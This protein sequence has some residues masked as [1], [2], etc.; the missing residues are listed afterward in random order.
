MSSITTDLEYYDN[1][2]SGLPM[3]N[4]QFST[5]NEDDDFYYDAELTL[6]NETHYCLEL[7]PPTE[8]RTALDLQNN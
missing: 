7:M 3:N 8:V 2:T 6:C 5:S 4:D 1:F